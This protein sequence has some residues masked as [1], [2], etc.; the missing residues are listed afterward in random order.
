M[1]T[2]AEELAEACRLLVLQRQNELII[3]ASNISASLD[4][5]EHAFGNFKK[6]VFR[7]REYAAL[8]KKVSENL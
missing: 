5:I 1:A 6:A 7:H 8:A 4:S 3:V 2:E